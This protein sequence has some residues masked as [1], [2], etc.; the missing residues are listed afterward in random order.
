MTTRTAAAPLMRGRRGWERRAAEQVAAASAH[1]RRIPDLSA[2]PPLL[3]GTGSFATLRERLA[4]HEREVPGRRDG[5]RHAG[6]TSVPHGAK[7][8]LAAALAVAADERICWIARD[9]EIGDRVAE[10]LGAWLGDPGLVVV[11]EPRTA[12][13]YE[14]SELVA[15][16]TAARVAALAGWRAGHARIL[17]ASVQALLQHTIAPEDLPSEARVLRGGSR[18]DQSRLLRDLLELGYV[19]AIEVA[20]KGE[21]ARRGGIVDVF[22]PSAEL[23]VRIEWFGD[24]VE[25]LRRFDPTDQRSVDRVDEVRLL[26]ASE[27]LLP[28]G[29]GALRTRLGRAATKLPERLAADLARLTGEASPEA[30]DG[31]FGGATPIAAGS[32]A[33]DV[34]DAAEVWAPLLAPSTGLDHLG[35]AALFVIDEPGDVAEAG[36]FL[37]R[38]AD[39]RRAE[40]VASGEPPKDWPPNLL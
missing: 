8:F 30:G 16:E 19:P 31:R 11:L 35:A 6:L 21:F 1:G 38:Q 12:L 3:A 32:R 22:P 25:S 18:V 13:A 40:L 26:P 29:G 28:R 39:E 37:W 9:A 34:G 15:D 33:A 27:F 24:E 20:G 5:G 36:A 23:P 7:S 4:R 10:E 17:V 14:R 2:L